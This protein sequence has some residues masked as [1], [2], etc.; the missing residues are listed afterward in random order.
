MASAVGR[1]RE[2][3]LGIAV[4]IEQVRQQVLGMVAIAGPELQPGLGFLV[5]GIE[6]PLA[7]DFLQAPKLLQAETLHL[8]N[9]A[10][11]QAL[12]GQLPWTKPPLKR[13]PRQVGHPRPQAGVDHKISPQAAVTTGLQHAQPP[14]LPQHPHQICPT[15]H[16]DVGLTQGLGQGR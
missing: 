7:E 14:S 15:Q 6:E 12:V 5:L 4:L 13:H 1:I 16:R 9:P 8:K 10:Q 11:G 3:Q 2:G